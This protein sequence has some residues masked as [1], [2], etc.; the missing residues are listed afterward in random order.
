MYALSPKPHEDRV[1]LKG[2]PVRFGEAC[3][4]WGGVAGL[5]GLRA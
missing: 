3:G 4:F 1:K 5:Q 2:P